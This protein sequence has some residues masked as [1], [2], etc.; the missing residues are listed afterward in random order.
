MVKAISQTEKIKSLTTLVAKKSKD[1]L[2]TKK[3]LTDSKKW[4]ESNPQ[5]GIRSVTKK[6]PSPFVSLNPAFWP[7]ANEIKPL[8]DAY[9]KNMVADLDFHKSELSKARKTKD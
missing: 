2:A 1:L 5:F 9:M 8:L 7:R 3:I 4:H 6:G